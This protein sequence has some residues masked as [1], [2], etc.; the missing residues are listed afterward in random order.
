MSITLH[1]AL[2]GM[3]YTKN[4]PMVAAVTAIDTPRSTKLL[5]TGVSA[6]DDS[7]DQDESLAN[8]KLFA[9]NIDERSKHRGGRKSLLTESE[10][11]PI[12]LKEEILPYTY[13]REPTTK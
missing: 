5:G 9:C 4:L 13:I 6:Y 2:Y 8:P 1:V 7:P 12:D 3:E 11:I 10:E